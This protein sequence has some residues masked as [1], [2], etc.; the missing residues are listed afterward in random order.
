MAN[1]PEL[2]NLKKEIT[3]LKKEISRLGG[4]TFKDIDAA[5]QSLGGGLNGAQKV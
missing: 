1:S 3:N 2:N 5:I 4:D